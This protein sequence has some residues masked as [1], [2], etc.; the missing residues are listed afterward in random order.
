MGG[1][2]S[3]SPCVRAGAEKFSLDCPR[4]VKNYWKCALWKRDVEDVVRQRLHGICNCN[5]I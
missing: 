5:L 4:A 3:G 1:G 2:N